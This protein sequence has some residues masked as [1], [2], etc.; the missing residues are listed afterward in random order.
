VNRNRQPAMRRD[1]RGLEEHRNCLGEG[2]NTA[3]FTRTLACQ[4]GK[5]RATKTEKRGKK[6]DRGG[7]KSDVRRGIRRQDSSGREEKASKACHPKG[8]SQK[9]K[10]G[11]TGVTPSPQ[12]EG[13]LNPIT[14]Y[15]GHA[16]QK[17]GRGSSV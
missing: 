16:P 3:R 10:R 5:Q 9:G 12:G 2:G 14:R 4:W 11:Q 13:G 17:G 8:R 7:N 1:R 6:K 15:T